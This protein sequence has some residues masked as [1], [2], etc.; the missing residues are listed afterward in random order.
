MSFSNDEHPRTSLSDD[1][2]QRLYQHAQDVEK[3]GDIT[4]HVRSKARDLREAIHR[5]GTDEEI[6][7][8]GCE[9]VLSHLK[10][11]KHAKQ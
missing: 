9:V 10:D 7:S 1:D 4:G 8:K 2:R 6:L 11:Q 5:Q 3:S